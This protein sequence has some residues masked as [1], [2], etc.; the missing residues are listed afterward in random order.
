[1]MN[2]EAM[3]P[4]TGAASPVSCIDSLISFPGFLVSEFVPLSW[5]ALR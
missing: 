3:K 5:R 1:M 2:S 4:G